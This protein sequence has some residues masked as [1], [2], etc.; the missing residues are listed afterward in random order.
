MTQFSPPPPQVPGPA[1]VPTHPDRPDQPRSWSASAIGGFVL[2]L[3]GCVGV[4]AVLGL[5]LAIVGV[6]RTSGGVRRGRGLAIAAIPISVLTGVFSVFLLL[7]L[8]LAQS[9]MAQL[10]DVKAALSSADAASAAVALRG[11]C[12][13]DFNATVSDDDLRR[14]VEEVRAKHGKLVNLGLSTSRPRPVPG[15]PR[16]LVLEAKFVN[17]PAA[18]KIKLAR[19]DLTHQTIDDIEIDGSSPRNADGA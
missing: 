16:S 13:D 15:E 17:G 9:F 10:N 8:L 6:A 7:G 2:S 5:I 18:L 19:E 14:W 4:T 12:S 11:L 3:I 1:P